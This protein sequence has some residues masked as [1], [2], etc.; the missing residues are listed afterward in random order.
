MFFFT[1]DKETNLIARKMEIDDNVIPSSNSI[2]AHNLFKL[3]HYFENR[4]YSSNAQAML[5]NVKEN[6]LKYGAGASS[7]LDLYANYAGNYYEVAVVGENAKEKL[8]EIH[9]TYLPNKLIVGSTK[10]SNL[11][12]LAYKYSENQTTIYVCVDGACQLPVTESKEAFKQI[13]TSFK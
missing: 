13:K 6:A 11:P 2:M 9:Q 12:L 4:N 7:W 10:E 5:N 3:G 8:K 1:S